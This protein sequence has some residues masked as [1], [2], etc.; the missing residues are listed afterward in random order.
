MSREASSSGRVSGG[1]ALAGGADLRPLVMLSV[2][3]LLFNPSPVADGLDFRTEGAVLARVVA[4]PL[5]VREVA[6]SSSIGTAI[7]AIMEGGKVTVGVRC[8]TT[9][10]IGRRG[11]DTTGCRVYP[12]MQKKQRGRKVNWL[13][14]NG[15]TSSI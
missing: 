11:N 7:G 13:Q 5:D 1:I 6:F 8:G 15:I 2:M 9:N 3:M 10:R 12:G 4:T 14:K